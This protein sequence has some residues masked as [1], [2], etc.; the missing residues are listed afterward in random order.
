MSVATAGEAWST[1]ERVALWVA[2]AP[3]DRPDIEPSDAAAIVELIDG[4]CLLG[5]AIA[6][7]LGTVEEG[8]LGELL[9]HRQLAMQ[10]LVEDQLVAVEELIPE[11]QRKQANIDFVTMATMA[12]FATMMIL[13]VSLG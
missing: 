2:G 1:A 5:R 11:S 6:R 10:E 13:D 4:H 3:V 9:V 8:G 12:G 7:G